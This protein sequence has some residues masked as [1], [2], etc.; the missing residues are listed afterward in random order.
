MV[1]P[2][3]L[4][5]AGIVVGSALLVGLPTSVLVS[6]FV[7]G[8]TDWQAV[9][10]WLLPGIVVGTLVA[11]GRLSVAY[12]QVWLFSLVS[13]LAAL[14]FWAVLD[15]DPID[16]TTVT[17]TTLGAGVLALLVGALVA[18]ANPAIQWRGNAS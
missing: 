1:S 9:L 2:N 18:W 6:P 14:A 15:V 4:E 10:L 5:R 7:S 11:T 8:I 13:W 3:T 16:G 12:R 17:P